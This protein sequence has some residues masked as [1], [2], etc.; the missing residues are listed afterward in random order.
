MKEQAAV[1]RIRTLTGDLEQLLHMLGTSA[2][3]ARQTASNG[4]ASATPGEVVDAE[5]TEKR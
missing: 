3:E 2:Y 4:T 1:E 5:F